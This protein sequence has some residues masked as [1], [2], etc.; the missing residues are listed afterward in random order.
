MIEVKVPATS[1]NMGPGFDCMGIALNMYNH[2]YIEEIQSGLE[3]YG[4]EEA[5]RNEDN[6]IYTS[7]QKCFQLIGYNAAQRGLRIRIENDIPVSRGLGSS[8]ACILGGLLAANEIGNGNL[9][10][11]DILEIA[12]E[13]EGHPDN[14]APALFGGITV[15]IKEGNRV[16]CEKLP[17]AQDLKFCAI[18]PGFSLSTKESRSVLPE[19]IPYRDGV[20]NVGR[21]SL[22]IAALI[23]GN[24]DLLKLACR[25]RLHEIYR[26][27]LIRNYEGIVNES[28][29]L[30]S[31][32][33]F[34]SGAGPTIMA[35]LK[36]ED[37][38]FAIEMQKYLS[39]LEDKWILKELRPDLNGVSVRSI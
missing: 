1:A 9:N 34:L 28:S 39:E 4:C 14:I 37:S 23:N 8:A 20:F 33:T 24:Y 19:S 15:A 13:I 31:L 7:M 32:C 21:A 12:S 10:K 35:V 27:K 18:I 30:K 11:N 25:D 16:Y 2:F 5:F 6:L 36:D 17:V 22:F 3:I 29:R 26:G 38:E